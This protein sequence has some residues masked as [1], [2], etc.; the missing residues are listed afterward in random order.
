MAEL[1]AARAEVEAAAAADAARAA[2]AELEALRVSSTGNSVS[3][4]DD[5]DNELK[6]AREAAREQAAQWVAAHPQGRR[7][8]ALT[9]TDA[10]AT[11]R[12]GACA[13]AAQ[14][15][16]DASAVGL[17]EIA[18]VM[19]GAAL[20]PRTGT[21]VTMGSRPLS[22]TLVPAAGGLPSPK[23]TTSSGSR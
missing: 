12:A 18:T 9:G 20:P 21:M 19:G 13:A 15:G 6:L 14:T 5:R 10:P 3:A 23:S 1:T 16:A 7:A 8:A 22:G 4:D 2:A 11:L 17:T